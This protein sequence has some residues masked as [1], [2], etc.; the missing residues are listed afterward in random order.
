[1][2]CGLCGSQNEENAIFCA[3]C[4][5][6]LNGGES[7]NNESPVVTNEKHKNN[8]V[9]KIA[10]VAAAVIVVVIALIFATKS[11]KS[12]SAE[13]QESHDSG[14]IST[15]KVEG[16]ESSHSGKVSTCY[17]AYQKYY[18]EFYEEHI[19]NDT[20]YT[21]ADCGGMILL[22]ENGAPIMAVCDLTA[23]TDTGLSADIYLYEYDG[24]K[25]V[26]KAKKTGILCSDDGI[27]LANA[28]DGS[29][30][31][32]AIASESGDMMYQLEGNAFVSVPLDDNGEVFFDE[33]FSDDGSWNPLFFQLFTDN[34][35]NYAVRGSDFDNLL[36]QFAEKDPKTLLEL[37]IAYADFFA[38][39][40]IY[41]EPNFDYTADGRCYTYSYSE[42][43]LYLY[44]ELAGHTT[45]D[46]PSEIENIEVVISEDYFSNALKKMCIEDIT[47]FELIDDILYI[48]TNTGLHLEVPTTEADRA[49][50]LPETNTAVDNAVAVADAAVEDDLESEG[51]DVEYSW[52][53]YVDSTHEKYG[54]SY[55]EIKRYID[56]G[57]ASDIEFSFNGYLEKVTLYVEGTDE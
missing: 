34:G 54:S 47:G 3:E 39:E 52:E 18:D 56:A 32:Y 8:I 16:Q 7:E 26:E 37:R 19:S 25:V 10:V 44:K 35:N 13:E 29:V 20:E 57:T 11:F 23:W 28:T 43:T 5:A 31:M 36:S 46:I 2:F 33:H 53:I 49:P 45:S 6:R 17:G 4:G 24:K 30:G 27:L 38:K 21:I 12:R 9:V 42:K 15:D 14:K 50:S 40:G 22:D 48:D 55:D 51:K 41:A 1:M